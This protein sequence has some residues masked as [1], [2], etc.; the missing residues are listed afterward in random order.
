MDVP[1]SRSN[2]CHPRRKLPKGSLRAGLECGWSEADATEAYARLALVRPK[3][4]SHVR[5]LL[6]IE[7]MQKVLP[8]RGQ[9][10]LLDSL[11]EALGIPE[12]PKDPT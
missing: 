6:L 10:A 3:I 12:L 4:G 11:A 8:V 7:H 2:D 1:P 5:N 9:D